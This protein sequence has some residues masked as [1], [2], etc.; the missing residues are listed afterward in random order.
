V[1]CLLLPASRQEAPAQQHAGCCMAASINQTVKVGQGGVPFQ[2]FM[3][4]QQAG[5][6]YSMLL[7]MD[8]EKMSW[9]MH[10]TCALY[11]SSVAIAAA[12]E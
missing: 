1:I 5:S 3:L 11:D 10:P 12:K 7:S 8:Q 9:A 6:H 4:A 2:L